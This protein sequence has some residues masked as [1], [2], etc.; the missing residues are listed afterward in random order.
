M[1]AGAVTSQLQR[2]PSH[3]AKTLAVLSYGETEWPKGGFRDPEWEG[4]E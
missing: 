4:K 2:E 1:Q 3:V